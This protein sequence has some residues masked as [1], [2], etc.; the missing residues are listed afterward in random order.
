[1]CLNSRSKH[2]YKRPHYT[3]LPIGYWS[4]PL[5]S[6]NTSAST[7]STVPYTTGAWP[8][9]LQALGWA[10]KH[11]INVILDL[12]GAPG[13]QNGYDNSG[14]RTGSPVWGTTPDNV[15]RTVDT[16]KFLA[17]EVGSQVSV[18]ELL[19]EAAGFR[20]SDWAAVIRQFWLD[21]YAAVRSAAGSG[22]KIMIGDA[23]LGVD[24]SAC[25]FRTLRRGA[26]VVCC[27]RA[28]RTSLYLR[29]GK[30]C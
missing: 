17:K 22:L 27:G 12:H 18:I 4:I 23:F 14:Q 26:D 7:V 1:M 8:Y 6:S 10:Q 16:L 15:T 2:P 19:N 13:S 5:T 20:G 29:K 9:I 3:R 28:G 30:E 11:K 24:V 21:G 25:V